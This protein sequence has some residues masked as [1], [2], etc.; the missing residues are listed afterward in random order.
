MVMLSLV[1]SACSVLFMVVSCHMILGQELLKVT[2]F[3]QAT[4]MELRGAWE[5]TEG[6]P[7]GIDS[8][9]GPPRQREK[10]AS[11]AVPKSA[12]NIHLEDGR[13]PESLSCED[14]S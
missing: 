10:M 11:L 9:P 13:T 8:P 7:G 12:A 1:V 14:H 5:K 4:V 3:F 2:G 6:R